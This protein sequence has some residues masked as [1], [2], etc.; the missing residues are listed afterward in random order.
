[1]A[2]RIG[3][4]DVGREKMLATAAVVWQDDGRPAG[5][6]SSSGERVADEPGPRTSIG[7]GVRVAPEPLPHHESKRV[8]T[9]RFDS[10]Q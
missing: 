8:R 7:I 6:R 4:R 5:R 3:L 9:R 1:M 2:G 10:L